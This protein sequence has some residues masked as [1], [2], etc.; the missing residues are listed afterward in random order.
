MMLMRCSTIPQLPSNFLA[1]V[2]PASDHE[3]IWLALTAQEEPA[4]TTLHKNKTG[5]I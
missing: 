2:F 1:A 3:L 5:A 4:T